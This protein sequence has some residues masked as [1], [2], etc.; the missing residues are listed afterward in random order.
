MG[1]MDGNVG[2]AMLTIITD[3]ITATAMTGSL[4]QSLVVSLVTLS[5]NQEQYMFN[6]SHK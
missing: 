5:L 6:H 4:Q 1:T 3:T 2:M